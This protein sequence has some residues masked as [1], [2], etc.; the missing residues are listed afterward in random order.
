MSE[1][2]RWKIVSTWTLKRAPTTAQ[3]IK[4]CELSENER[5][6]HSVQEFEKMVDCSNSDR[7]KKRRKNRQR[8]KV[9]DTKRSKRT[10]KQWLGKGTESGEIKENLFTH[11]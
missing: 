10:K 1:S 5:D 6:S 2:E 9:A 3:R 8:H 4:K 11:P 7:G